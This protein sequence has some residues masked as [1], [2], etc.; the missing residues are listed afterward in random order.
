MTLPRHCWSDGW[1]A[2]EFT[3]AASVIRV[4]DW[5]RPSGTV[6]VAADHHVRQISTADVYNSSESMIWKRGDG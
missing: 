6:S 5:K 1:V 2:G 4:L 3:A